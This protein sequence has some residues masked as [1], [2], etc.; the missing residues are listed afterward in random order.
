VVPPTTRLRNPGCELS[1][2]RVTVV[3]PVEIVKSR[4]MSKKL[5]T[6]LLII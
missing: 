1:P 4:K 6:V 3:A 5:T 2:T